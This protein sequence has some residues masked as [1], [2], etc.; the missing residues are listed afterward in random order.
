MNILKRILHLL[1]SMF[2]SVKSGARQS[3]DINGDGA[4]NFEDVSAAGRAVANNGSVV[5]GSVAAAVTVAAG[6]AAAGAVVGSAMVGAKASAIGA[7][8][9]T[10]A[11][12]TAGVLGGLWA[13][14]TAI[15]GLLVTQIG[16]LVI[17][18][19]ATL[20]TV[21]APVVA[22]WTTT[23]TAAS[24]AAEAMTGFV[25]GM[26]LIQSAAASSLE[27][28]GK[29]VLIGG[30]PISIQAAIVAGFVIALVIAGIAYYVLTSE[31][32]QNS[33]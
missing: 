14:T 32:Q 27:A 23:A 31:G 33:D 29:V 17:I 20:M 7:T 5:A 4:L 28:A 10:A 19:S 16:S 1:A 26:P 13:G 6:S 11:G 30:A 18:E 2:G 24:A 8:L 15:P 22:A 21:S 25:A 12:A 9:A 3:L